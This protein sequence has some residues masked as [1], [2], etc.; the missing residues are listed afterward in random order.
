MSATLPPL[1]R[2][3]DVL[4]ILRVSKPTLWAWRRAGRFPEPL[5]LGPNTVAW[6]EADVRRWIEKRATA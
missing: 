4:A 1:L 5:R 3:K 6:R 2:T